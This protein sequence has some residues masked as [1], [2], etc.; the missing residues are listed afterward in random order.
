MGF[1][2]LRISSEVSQGASLKSKEVQGSW[3]FLTE[4]ILGL[5]F[6]RRSMGNVVRNDL[7]FALAQ[8]QKN[9]KHAE[10]AV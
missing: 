4:M 6:L 10:S 2:K 5:L 1:N 8:P 3:Q 9:P 7:G